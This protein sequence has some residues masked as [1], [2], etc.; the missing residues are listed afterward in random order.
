MFIALMVSFAAASSAVALVVAW[1]TLHAC[2]AGAK[3]MDSMSLLIAKTT[4][5]TLRAE[6]DDLRGALDV[7][8]ASNRKEF[9]SL[10]GRLGGKPDT[11][12]ALPTQREVDGSFAALLDLQSRPPSGPQ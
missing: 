5:E 4:P 2:A 8:R 3:R 10:W 11:A 7:L 12:G 1:S 6:V 9:G